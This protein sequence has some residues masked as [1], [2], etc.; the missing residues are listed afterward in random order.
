VTDNMRKRLLLLTWHGG[1]GGVSKMVYEIT[2]VLKDS[3]DFDVNVGYAKNGGIYCEHI[4]ELNIPVKI[5]NMKSGFDILAAFKIIGYLKRERFDIVHLHYITPLLR[6]AAFLGSPNLILTE[7]CGIE[8]RNK[9]RWWLLYYLISKMMCRVIGKIN[10]TVSKCNKSDLV[11][12]SFFSKADQ[13]I[14]IPNGVDKTTFSSYNIRE[15]AVLPDAIESLKGKKVIGIIRGLIKRHGIDH[16]I[17]MAKKL[18][19]RNDLKFV[20]IGEGE[21]YRRLKDS[22]DRLGLK[23]SVCF[24]GLLEDPLIPK[25]LSM[26]KAAI[27]PSEYEGFGISAIEAMAMEIPVIAYASGGICEV[28][29]DG[30]TGI[31]VYDRKPEN[32]AQKV[33]ELLDNEALAKEMGKRARRRVE[34]SYDIKAIVQKYVD[35][36]KHL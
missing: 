23:N 29:D 1:A 7:H 6:L 2:R 9:K 8:E 10:T 26:L 12:H 14:I 34:A 16:F 19:H 13:I 11:K 24:T 3:N 18:E 32:L 21:E 22:V 20:I 4:K 28:I 15:D 36:Y 35:L 17:L 31:L 27:I 30:V 5:F 25:M 33:V